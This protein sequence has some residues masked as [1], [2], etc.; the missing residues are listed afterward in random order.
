MVKINNIEE[1]DH[2]RLNALFKRRGRKITIPLFT[3]RVLEILE[4]DDKEYEVHQCECG[5]VS[6]LRT[7]YADYLRKQLNTEDI[8]CNSCLELSDLKVPGQIFVN[9]SNILKIMERRKIDKNQ[10]QIFY[11]DKDF[12]QL[13]KE[14]RGLFA[15]NSIDEFYFGF[16]NFSNA[17]FDEF[18]EKES[19]VCYPLIL[20]IM[21]SAIKINQNIFKEFE[22]TTD[23]EGLDAASLNVYL[24]R[25]S[26]IDF[27]SKIS[28]E[29]FLKSEISDFHSSE[30]GTS[31][32]KS[33]IKSK[34]T[35]YKDLVE[36]KHFLDLLLNLINVIEGR[37][38]VS[39]PFD[40]LKLP[41]KRPEGKERKIR[42]LNDKIELFKYHSF[43]DELYPLLSDIFDTKLRN[44]E[45]H[46]T[47][48]I[49][50]EK[51]VIRSTRYNKETT[52]EELGE[53]IDKISSFH[54]FL[55]EEW[56]KGYSETKKPL[57]KN[58]GIEEISLGYVDPVLID[59]K[60]FPNN[61]C[62]SELGIYQ[63]WDFAYYE[64]EKRWIPIPE[65]SFNKG[66]KITFE[67]GNTFDYELDSDVELWLCQ[68]VFYG[69]YNLSLYTIAPPLPSFNIKSI[70]K[71]P[72]GS[73]PEV[74]ILEV[75][76]KVIELPKKLIKYISEKI[77]L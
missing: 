32:F 38:V 57:M 56:L 34:M 35:E 51:K 31:H 64:N 52:F 29:K 72:V 50:T 68:L 55:S 28:D 73:M 23:A 70:T 8:P 77:N 74:N 53:K 24:V 54:S 20:E 59:D 7:D 30:T 15:T 63:Y 58:L 36:V 4:T 19:R 49:D 67:N 71:I 76:E 61:N 18:P 39:N 37:E 65:L 21:E 25:K 26:R 5:E 42:G 46:N 2:E 75:K 62:M 17:L 48:E 6:I 47:Y 13:K 10:Q 27:S 12:E 3:K 69:A 16:Y 44:D 40:K 11:I 66:F 1:I 41:P 9:L 14:G 45:A 22:K 60:L 43:G 33:N